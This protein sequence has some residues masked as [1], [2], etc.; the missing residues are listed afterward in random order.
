MFYFESNY[1]RGRRHE[2]ENVGGAGCVIQIVVLFIA[3]A[4]IWFLVQAI[5]RLLTDVVNSITMFALRHY[6]YM[7]LLG[8]GLLFF[9]IWNSLV[10]R[11]PMVRVWPV[12]IG[13]LILLLSYWGYQIMKL[14]SEIVGSYVR[15]D[16]KARLAIKG[17]SIDIWS[18]KKH[19]NGRCELLPSFS[20]TVAKT[21]IRGFPSSKSKSEMFGTSI[22][23]MYGET[24]YRLEPT[25]DSLFIHTDSGTIIRYGRTKR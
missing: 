5:L 24:I 9:G 25:A 4:F 14:P 13:S 16:Y 8:V 23:D 18:G 6:V 19:L 2:R 22:E 11:K 7:L 1:E 21:R 3:V 10:G 15:N 17:D 12:V 20:Y